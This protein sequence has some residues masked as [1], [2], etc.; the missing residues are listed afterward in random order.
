MKSTDCLR[1]IA[2]PA[3]RCPPLSRTMKQ[4]SLCSSIVQGGGKRRGVI[5]SGESNA[6]ISD[7]SHQTMRKKFPESSSR[8]DAPKHYLPS[9]SSAGLQTFSN[10]KCNART[11]G[12]TSSDINAVA[13]LSQQRSLP[14]LPTWSHTAPGR[15]NTV[16]STYPEC[17]GRVSIS[18]LSRLKVFEA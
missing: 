11:N 6:V 13:N 17:P 2:R 3:I 15:P 9:G 18:P 12:R 16:R 1:F 4:A 7:A 14:A 10:T 8:F 5:T